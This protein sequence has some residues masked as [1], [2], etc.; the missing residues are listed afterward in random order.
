VAINNYKKYVNECFDTQ[1]VNN[2][3]SQIEK[4]LRLQIHSI[5]IDTIVDTNPL[6]N[7][8]YDHMNYLNM[9]DITIFERRVSLKRKAEQYL[10]EKFYE[11]TA[12]TPYDWRTYEHIRMM[13]KEIYG[14][15][16]GE[17]HLPSKTTD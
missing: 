8:V 9:D 17:T 6:E 2:F 16:I 1:I 12:L 7:I 4:D 13:A 10:T 3:C 14:L 11:M 5:L 15:N